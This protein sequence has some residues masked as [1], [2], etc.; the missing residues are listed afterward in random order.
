MV[1]YEEL[2]IRIW[3]IGTQRYFILANG[4]ETAGAVMTLPNPAEF[5]LNRLN[6]LLLEE[7][8]RRPVNKEELQQLGQELYKAFF[9]EPI[10]HCLRESFRLAT[11][12]GRGLRVRFDLDAELMD[13]PLEVLHAPPG[14]PLRFL[15]FDSGISVVRSLPGNP[16]GGNR[17]MSPTGNP[18]HLRLFIVVSSP[19]HKEWLPLN[20]EAEIKGLTEE[21]RPFQQAGWLSWERIGGVPGQG[22]ATLARLERV[23]N[24]S[25]KDATV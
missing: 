7:F 10:S 15:V 4:P 20:V 8:N 21:L 24:F 22:R 13:V 19:R 5:Y 6:G 23:I 12:G 3:K 14:D 9:P 17:A 16:I 1:E 25:V 11:K 2:R 18:E